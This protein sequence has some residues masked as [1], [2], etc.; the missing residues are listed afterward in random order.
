MENIFC[1]MELLKMEFGKTEKEFS[2]F[3]NIYNS[4]QFCLYFF[5][6]KVDI[7]LMEKFW[8]FF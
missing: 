2:G 5:I 8:I 3:E 7:F 6:F 4:I 1:K